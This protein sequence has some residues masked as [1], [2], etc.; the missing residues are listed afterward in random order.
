MRTLLW[1]LAPACLAGCGGGVEQT[2]GAV[3]PDA[4]SYV[5]AR[6]GADGG[7]VDEGGVALGPDGGVIGGDG[8][9]IF[10]FDGSG[11]CA[12]QTDCDPQNC[13]AMGHSCNNVPCS[14]ALCAPVWLAWDRADDMVLDD[15]NL[16]FLNETGV[17]GRPKGVSQPTYDVAGPA[18]SYP[19]MI[20][21]SE[22][23]LTIAGG[24]LYWSSYVDGSGSIESALASAPV[25]ARG[26]SPDVLYQNGDAGPLSFVS[27]GVGVSGPS[28]YAMD[29]CGGL[30]SVPLTGGP[31]APVASGQCGPDQISAAVIDAVD[32][33]AFGLEVS[34]NAIRRVHISDGSV[35]TLPLPGSPTYI[36][37]VA[38]AV[39]GGALF[40][41]VRAGGT[42]FSS[43]LFTVALDGTSPRMIAS[44]MDFGGPIVVDSS[45]AYFRVGQAIARV[46]L[47]TGA[48]L[49]VY[50]WPSVLPEVVDPVQALALDDRY[51][52]IAQIDPN[53][54]FQVGK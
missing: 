53:A 12:V 14:Q 6:A 34:S 33:F 4:T 19:P 29:L 32:G 42:S 31:L 23:H 28:L 45:A 17:H 48:I 24:A 8:S 1:V 26:S 39:G 50:Q 15:S 47:S 3:P 10:T 7:A 18:V 38:L 43:A 20:V 13:G 36:Q 46:D 52:Y 40:V 30:S 51:L 2:G 27:R 25:S 21:Q 16:Y 44:G 9:T 22:Q 37:P 11:P 54:I 41:V 5:D 49:P 35:T